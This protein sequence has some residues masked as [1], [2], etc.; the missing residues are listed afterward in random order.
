MYYLLELDI[1]I[2]FML[3]IQFENQTAVCDPLSNI[4][5]DQIR[6]KKNISFYKKEQKTRTV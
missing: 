6:K 1:L 5:G 2:H 3:L 4:S